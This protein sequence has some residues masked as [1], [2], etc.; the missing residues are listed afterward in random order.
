MS[1]QK[2][3]YLQKEKSFLGEKKELF[4]IFKGLSVAKDRIKPESAF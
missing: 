4:I 1:K 3:K 2:L